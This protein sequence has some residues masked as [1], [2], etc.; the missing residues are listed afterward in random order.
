[1]NQESWQGSECLLELT[2]P[3][4]RPL[5]NQINPPARGALDRFTDAH[6]PALDALQ[7]KASNRE[8]LDFVPTKS[9]QG[10]SRI[11]LK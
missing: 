5:P 2:E 6:L 11:V 8:T 9:C 7:K 3:Q 1:M 4:R 10:S